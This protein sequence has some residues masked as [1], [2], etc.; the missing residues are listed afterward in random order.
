MP[1]PRPSQPSRAASVPKPAQAADPDAKGTF[2]LGRYRVV[3]E[4]GVGG[5]A[6]V[7][8]G[9]MDGPGGFQ[10]W[11]AIKRIH[12]HLVEH[13]QFVD[14]F[15]DEARIAAGI[16]HANVA[17]VFDL[18][19]DDNTYWIAMEY[20]HG[21]PLREL[22]RR[23]E[24]GKP[25][26]GPELA[27][28]IISD[29]AEGLH[30][31]HELRGRN[32]Q[33]LGLVHRDVTPHNLFITYD[34]YTKVVDFGIAKVADRLSTTNAGTLKG[35]LA[36]M[37]PE[38]VRGADIDRTTDVFALGV[39]LWELTTGQRLFRM[40]TDLDTLEKVQA[41]LVPPPSSI[42]EGYP[43]EL[44]AIVLKA[45]S[46][47]KAE[48]FATAREF[49]RALQSFLMK[50][51]NFIGPEEVSEFVGKVFADRIKKR[52]AHLAWA[53]EVTSTI[54]VDELRASPHR[55]EGKPQDAEEISA[56]SYRSE[57]NT[58]ATSRDATTQSSTTVDVRGGAARM[59]AASPGAASLMDDD[60]DVP[61]TIAHRD[62]LLSAAEAHAAKLAAPRPAAGTPGRGSRP[63]VTV[64]TVPVS[65]VVTPSSALGF[66]QTQIPTPTE[67][68]RGVPQ[69]PD[70]LSAAVPLLVPK[71]SVPGVL[72]QQSA[73]RTST[74]LP[75][76]QL[77]SLGFDSIAG[78]RERMTLAANV[79]LW[80]IGVVGLGS[81]AWARHG[82]PPAPAEQARLAVDST[83][84]AGEGR[85]TSIAAQGTTAV[86]AAATS[87]AV[88]P[89]RG[90]SSGDGFL[91][92]VCTPY[93]DD[94][95]VLGKSLGH[96][97]VVRHP[98]RPGAHRIVA[99]RT[100]K[101]ARAVVATVKAG[102][103]TT[104]RIQMR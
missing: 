18:G 5:M 90:A 43:I 3:D 94:V 19:K 56:E 22:M 101:P 1:P 61:T 27:A 7:H 24:P 28:K 6:S 9:R 96:S 84:G 47:S 79:A 12:P 73:V 72:E 99:K 67:Q 69:P 57:P 20:L 40:D 29:A 44:E 83:S 2:F 98:I 95:A 13:D 15:L 89:T 77:Q 38:Q 50:R 102:E 8:L 92:I 42:I 31:A 81:L 65:E 46:K 87:A 23:Q 53:S 26:V 82:L 16:N 71:S 32:G 91:T 25:I 62:N 88:P 58:S 60:E 74:S 66:A 37:S 100:G 52:E 78:V 70:S 33:L 49:S 68:S 11:V 48:R 75:R 104:E 103:V 14:M 54:N 39:V 21:E 97:P 10:K 80:V 17:Q 51:G 4:I 34:G 30:A 63:L 59:G 64:T 55:K 36:Y 35:K 93:C 86:A 41:C 85:A 76:P 45:L